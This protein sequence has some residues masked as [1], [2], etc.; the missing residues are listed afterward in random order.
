MLVGVI[1]FYTAL[2]YNFSMDKLKAS[3]ILDTLNGVYSDAHCELNF[4]SPFQ[5]LVATI[6]SAQCTDKRV[7]IITEKLFLKYNK[8]EDFASLDYLELEPLIFSCGFYHNKAK[9]IINCSRELLISYG[10]Q[11]PN[12]FDK[13]LKLSG[14]GRK[15]ANV[16]MAN[17]FGGDN[18]AVDTHVFRVSKRLGFSNGKTPFEVE[19]NLM[20]LFEKNQYSK[21]HHILIFHGRY[22]CKSQK[23]MC[24]NCHVSGDCLYYGNGAKY[25]EKENTYE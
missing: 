5:L 8:P 21:A 23:P 14:V 9:S 20:Q 3:E 25:I 18:I 4:E 11:V 10:G 22:C 12:D 13:L 17:A 2:W 1:A 19:K 15:T 7:N 24:R 6:L 16:V